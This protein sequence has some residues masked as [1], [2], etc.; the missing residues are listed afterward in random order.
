M[1]SIDEIRIA[2]LRA[3]RDEQDVYRAL[4]WS[5]PKWR[6]R[7]N[8]SDLFTIGELR[9]LARELGIPVRQLLATGA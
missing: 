9:D 5:W 4:G 2:I 1:V 7:M 8:D 6:R 3:Q